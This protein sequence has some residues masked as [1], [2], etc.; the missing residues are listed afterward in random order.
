MQPLAQRMLERMGP[1]APKDAL[2][3]AYTALVRAYAVQ[4]TPDKAMEVAEAAAGVGV[5]VL[6]AGW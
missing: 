1:T 2:S 5:E 3:G 4:D 6:D